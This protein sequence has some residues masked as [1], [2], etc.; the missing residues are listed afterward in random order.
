MKEGVLVTHN[1][2]K[3]KRETG[4]RMTWR[5]KNK[6]YIHTYIVITYIH[7]YTQTKKEIMQVIRKK[8]RKK[9]RNIQ[10]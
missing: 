3:E 1:K 2:R 8:G 9:E 6:R 5:K 10:N 4:E 7:T